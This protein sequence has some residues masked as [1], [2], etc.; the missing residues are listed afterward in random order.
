MHPLPQSPI[1]H[2]YSR[3]MDRNIVYPGAIPLDTDLLS[4]NRNTMVALG[5]MM[6]AILGV[7]VVVDGLDCSPTVPASM[8]VQISPGSLSQLS[9]VDAM[10]FGSLGADTSD[11]IVKMGI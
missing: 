4:I 3:S 11:Q 2:R 1:Q 5:F 7:E 6:R 8:S 10:P 9:I